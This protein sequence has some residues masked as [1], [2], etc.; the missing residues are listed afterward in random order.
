M[1]IMEKDKQQSLIIAVTIPVMMIVVMII[2]A[3]IDV[4]V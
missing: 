4:L 3:V 2:T 1:K